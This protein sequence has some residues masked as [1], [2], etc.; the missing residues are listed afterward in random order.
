M[1]AGGMNSFIGRV[2]LVAGQRPK[3]AGVIFISRVRCC[4]SSAVNGISRCRLLTEKLW[5]LPDYG[6][7]GLSWVLGLISNSVKPVSSTAISN[8]ASGR[9]P[10]E[11]ADQCRG[12][13]RILKL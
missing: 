13:I 4:T 12:E 9:D 8:A 1:Y 10:K 2:G 11:M 3:T 7:T 5:R 6:D